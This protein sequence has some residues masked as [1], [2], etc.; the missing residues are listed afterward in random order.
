MNHFEGVPALPAVIV[1]RCGVSVRRIPPTEYQV[2]VGIPVAEGDILDDMRAFG[3]TIE[4]EVGCRV[5]GGLV[6][7]R[8][9]TVPVTRH[10]RGWI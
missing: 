6:V 5:F 10:C 4:V 7:I 1:G 3:E 9:P 2:E 8:S